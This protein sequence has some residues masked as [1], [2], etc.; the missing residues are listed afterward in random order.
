MTA[1]EPAL[2]KNLLAFVSKLRALNASPSHT[3]LRAFSRTGVRSRVHPSQIER[4]PSR[5]PRIRAHSGAR[6]AGCSLF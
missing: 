6:S 2:A 5:R 1:S 4:R 3:G